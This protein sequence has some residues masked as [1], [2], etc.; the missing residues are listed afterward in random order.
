[1]RFLYPPTLAVLLLATGIACGDDP[2]PT[3]AETPVPTA[4][5]KP[6]ET[7]VPTATPT[8]TPPPIPAPSPT[9]T[10]EQPRDLLEAALLKTLTEGFAFNMQVVIDFEAD[11]EAVS[12]PITYKGDSRIVYTAATISAALPDETIESSVQLFD[13]GLYPSVFSFDEATQSWESGLGAAER[14]GTAL[15]FV[16]LT[17]FLDQ[18]NPSYG[19]RQVLG[20]VE[21]HVVSGKIGSS[22][23]MN[24]DAT[25]RI[26]VENGLL[27]QA[28][29]SG[30]I[31]F[32]RELP[33]AFGN[34]NSDEISFTM[35]WDLS[36]HGKNVPVVLPD[37]ATHIFGHRAVAL[38]D[39]RVLISGGNSGI[40]N[41]NVIIPIPLPFVQVYDPGAATWTIMDPLDGHSALTSAV[42]L[43]DG[44]VLLV[45]IGADDTE[46][47]NVASLF[48]PADDSWERIPG[49]PA[50]RGTPHLAL[51]ADDRVLA[52][53]GINLETSMYSPDPS[54][55]V[56]IFDPHTG[57]WERKAAMP[58]PFAELS[59]A[60]LPDGR[61][62]VVGHPEDP[63][64][65][66]DSTWVYDPD[67]DVW[68]PF[69]LIQDPDLA[70]YPEAT[71]RPGPAILL[72]DGK[73]L[74]TGATEL[75]S[76]YSS[77]PEWCDADLPEQA[78]LLI[79]DP[80]RTTST[81]HGLAS[82]TFAFTGPV[83]HARTGHTLTLLQDGRVLAAGGIDPGH[84]YEYSTEQ[85]LIAMT[86][87]YDPATD[88]WTKGPDLSEPR[89][90]H[91][92]TLLP[93]GR[94]LLVGGI[95]QEKEP[96]PPGS[97]KEVYPLRHAEILDLRP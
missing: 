6:T 25:L 13:I 58:N 73:L 9:P 90:Q 31:P 21:T 75:E 23:G 16:N 8:P 37:L 42:K 46:D 66:P 79:P 54:D 84:P 10:P 69:V 20:T 88:I 44:R 52:I 63:Y 22:T 95:G 83:S 19:E 28:E 76:L 17:S 49:E 91:T 33:T 18:T 70:E 15:F 86:E 77:S 39:G 14:L 61:A 26:G 67:E 87:I 43:A 59:L 48:D 7:P 68:E 89:Y 74:V 55:I 80:C 2:A 34:L 32:E 29:A 78:D 36:E 35:T 45:G 47:H 60:I 94:V 93:D 56:E 11:G 53:G 3:P 5:A 96:N 40:A 1:M 64:D 51:L 38:D 62:L 12:V 41:N 71:Q 92:A 27:L 57:L 72:P 50:L 65:E 85:N 97:G 82:G 81:V 4:A 30:S 24:G